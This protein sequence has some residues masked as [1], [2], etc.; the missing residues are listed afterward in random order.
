MVVGLR[1]AD[2]PL[3]SPE[4]EREMAEL[5]PPLTEVVIVALEELPLGVDTDIGEIATP[6]FGVG[7]ELE[8]PLMTQ[9]VGLGGGAGDTVTGHV[10]ARHADRPGA[11]CR[12]RDLDLL[13][14]VGV[15]GAGGLVDA[16]RVVDRA[17][18]AS[19]REVE[20]VDQLRTRARGRR[21][22]RSTPG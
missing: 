17:A 21:T 4:A 13:D 16:V 6:K 3:G 12:A 10:V 5:K 14:V 2:A 18:R 9:R 15:V 8:M 20:V 1:L 19:D 7:T 22:D 11:A